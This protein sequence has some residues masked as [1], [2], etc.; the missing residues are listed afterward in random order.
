MKCAI[1]TITGTTNYGNVLQILALQTVL[2][3]LSAEAAAIKSPFQPKASAYQKLKSTVKNILGRGDKLRK[4]RI[5]EFSSFNSKY[6]KFDDFKN[7]GSYDYFVCG[8][9]Q[10]WNPRLVGGHLDYYFASFA[11]QSKRV[12][13]SASIGINS[14]DES[15]HNK[16][17]TNIKQMKSISVREETAAELIKDLTGTEVCVTVDPTLMLSKDEWMN[18]AEKPSFAKSKRFILTYFI[19]TSSPEVKEYVSKVAKEAN[20]EIINLQSEWQNDNE[21]ENK[22]Q[23]CA[24]PSE[25]IWLA[26]NCEAFFTDSFHGSC[27]SII[28]RKPLRYFTRY[29]KDKSD[30]TSRMSNLFDRLKISEWCIGS[31]QEK[32]E[33]IFFSDYSEVTQIIEREKAA[34]FNYLK[35]ALSN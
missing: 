5:K 8:S 26:A 22:E 25:F 19:G 14:I 12:A 28:M 7:A 32:A 21:I 3:K 31:T 16:F 2:E 9:D 6:I 11:P 33:H 29:E 15:L 24:V 30:T 34:A 18:F 27:F 20:C 13:F 4:K 23:F 17:S 10:I 1:I 35:N